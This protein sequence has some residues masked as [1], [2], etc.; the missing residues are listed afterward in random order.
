VRGI[1]L[2]LQRAGRHR[3]RAPGPARVARDELEPAARHLG[4]EM[5]SANARRAASDRRTIAYIG[6]FNS[7]ASAIS[8]PIS[9]R[10]ASSSEP[11]NTAIG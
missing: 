2:A 8:L 6:E 7:G 11:S 4:A 10:R 1:E 5:V 3:R 9:T